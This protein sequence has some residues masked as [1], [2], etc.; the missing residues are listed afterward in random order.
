MRQR[1]HGGRVSEPQ[2]PTPAASRFRVQGTPSVELLDTT[3]TDHRAHRCATA[4]ATHATRS[5]TASSPGSTPREPGERPSRRDDGFRIRFAKLKK[6]SL[7]AQSLTN[8]VRVIS[9][10]IL[11]GST[12][13]IV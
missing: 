11:G 9:R 2:V 4:A 3:G 12:M 7:D 1:N 6:D 8:D 5:S 10:R 13:T